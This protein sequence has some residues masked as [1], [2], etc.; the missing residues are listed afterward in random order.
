MATTPQDQQK[1]ME[2]TSECSWL[3]GT[4]LLYSG[5]S[6]RKKLMQQGVSSHVC[7]LGHS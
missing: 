3:K 6:E 1:F 5:A 2:E 7:K 4:F